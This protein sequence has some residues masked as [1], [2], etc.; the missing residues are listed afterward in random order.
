MSGACAPCVGER[1]AVTGAAI[2]PIGSRRVAL[3]VETTWCVPLLELAACTF[4]PSAVL[5]SQITACC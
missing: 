3:G 1:F 5:R 2:G 4:E